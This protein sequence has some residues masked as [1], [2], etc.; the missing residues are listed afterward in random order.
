MTICKSAVDD[1]LNSTCIL[2][3][4]KPDPEK[5]VRLKTEVL[6]TKIRAQEVDFNFPCFVS[7][8]GLS[9]IMIQSVTNPD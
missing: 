8:I 4:N 9:L 6:N 1:C 2:P 3:V 5:G 7:N